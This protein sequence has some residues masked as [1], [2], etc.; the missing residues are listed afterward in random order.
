MLQ[1]ILQ[2]Y[3]NTFQ[4]FNSYLH[5]QWYSFIRNLDQFSKKKC[6][7]RKNITRP[8]VKKK[9]SKPA[10]DSSLKRS[11]TKKQIDKEKDEETEE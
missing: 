8:K 9:K 5:S 3:Y 10:E 11:K 1:K 4:I 2:K 7:E 6:Y